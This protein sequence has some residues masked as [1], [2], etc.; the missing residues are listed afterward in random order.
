[1][2]A[3]RGFF[4]VFHFGSW[5]Y[6]AFIICANKLMGVNAKDVVTKRKSHGLRI[7]LFQIAAYILTAEAGNVLRSHA[8]SVIQ[9]Y[10][11]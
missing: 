3:R 11:V 2:Q 8:E 10:S 7:F 9:Y 1:M 6:T 5:R 4:N